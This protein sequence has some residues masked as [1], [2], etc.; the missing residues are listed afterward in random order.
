MSLRVNFESQ[1][2]DKKIIAD[3][4]KVAVNKPVKALKHIYLALASLG[5]TIN[6]YAVLLNIVERRLKL[7]PLNKLLAEEEERNATSA[8]EAIIHKLLSIVSKSKSPSFLRA[9]LALAVLRA[10]RNAYTQL[11]MFYEMHHE[12][13]PLSDILPRMTVSNILKTTKDGGINIT[14]S[15][16]ALDSVGATR[17]EYNKL[18]DIYESS[19]GVEPIN[20]M[21]P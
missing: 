15:H 3:L 14:R 2:L 13:T 19:E 4:L 8:R 10:P 18:L 1:S 20:S 5:A 12:L 6:D 9:Q 16:M 7:T 21:L 17:D 11:L